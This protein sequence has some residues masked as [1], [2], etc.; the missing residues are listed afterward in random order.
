MTVREIQG[1]LAEMY[2]VDVSPV[3]GVNYPGRPTTTILAG[4]SG[5]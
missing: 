4:G 2:S 1:F 5:E 3:V